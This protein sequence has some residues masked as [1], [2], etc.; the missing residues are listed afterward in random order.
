MARE[1]AG[2]LAGG[3]RFEIRRAP[4]DSLHRYAEWGDSLQ[5]QVTEE[6]QRRWEAMKREL[7]DLAEGLPRDI[8]GRRVTGF[9]YERLADVV[10]FN[11]NERRRVSG[12]E[13]RYSIR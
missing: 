13:R 11:R 10:R 12:C 5:L 8:S 3:G 4:R 7:A 1:T 6:D 9:G 2:L